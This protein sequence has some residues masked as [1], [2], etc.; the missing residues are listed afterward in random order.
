MC[1]RG[2]G[3]VVNVASI[4]GK[5]GNPGGSAYAA[6]KGGVIAYTKSASKELAQS[7]C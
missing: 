2:Y 7:E 1:E 3:R 5:E 4:A 6:S